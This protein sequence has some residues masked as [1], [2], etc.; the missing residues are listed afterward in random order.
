VRGA[1]LHLHLAGLGLP[2]A[3]DEMQNAGVAGAAGL[4]RLMTRVVQL[5]AGGGAPGRG[6]RGG[7]RP[8]A[9]DS[10]VGRLPPQDQ[11]WQHTRHFWLLDMGMLAGL[12]V[13]FAC[14]VRWKVRLR[15]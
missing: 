10:A 5:A 6:A 7:K 12:T 1:A 15:R 8:P 14:F 4:G 9:R 11:F 13:S 3:V 2:V